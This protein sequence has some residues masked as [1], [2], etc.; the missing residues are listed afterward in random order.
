[1][2]NKESLNF[3]I[4]L[5]SII[6]G[7]FYKISFIEMHRRILSEYGKIFYFPGLFGRDPLLWSFDPEDIEK[8]CAINY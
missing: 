4:N 5:Y 8:V 7:K 2:R 1:M 3:I 6:S